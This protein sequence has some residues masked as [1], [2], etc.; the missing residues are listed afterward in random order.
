MNKTLGITLNYNCV[1]WALTDDQRANP[2]LSMGV[3]VFPTTINHL[4]SGINEESQLAVRTKHRNM[5]RS[6]VRKKYRKLQ[7]LSVLIANKMCPCS[8]KSMEY[9]KTTGIF[10]Q[11]EL[12]SWFALDPYQLRVKALNK[13]I[14]LHELGR[15]CYHFSQRRGKLFSKISSNDSSDSVFNYGDSKTKRLGLAATLPYCKNDKR[16]GQHLYQ[17]QHQK[18]AP[19]KQKEERIRNRYLDRFMY[20][21][22]FHHIYDCQQQYHTSLSESL[23]EE[24]DGRKV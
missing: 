2:I 8:I 16:L 3:R 11:E 14:S 10:P 19:Y 24:L 17:F 13:K 7:L 9:W 5:R 15:I 12:A 4:G 20:V 21:K 1:S 23:R 22:E 6:L 18:H